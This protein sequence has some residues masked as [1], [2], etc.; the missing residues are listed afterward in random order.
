[1]TTVPAPAA[2]ATLSHQQVLRVLS[3]I[4]LGM[5]L[6]ALDQTII[7]TPLPSIAAEL[8]G[9]EHLSWVVAIYLLTSTVSTPIYGKLSDLY[10]RRRL[11]QCAIIIFICGSVLCALTQNMSQLI[12]ARAVQGLGGGG[13]ITLAHALLADHV[14]PRERGRYQGY[15][16]GTWATAS[17]GGPVLGGLFV[18]HLSWRWVFW[19]NLPIGALALLLCWRSLR[20]LP[21][22]YERRSIDYPGALLL[23]AGAASLLLVATW[24]GSQYPW[25]SAPILGIAAAGVLLFAL[26]LIQ[27]LR[28]IEPIL[29]PRLFRNDVFRVANSA[30]AVISMVV[31]GTTMLLPIFLQ[32][33]AGVSAA[34]SGLLMAPFTGTTVVGAFT[35][36]W[37]MRTTGRYK[38]M[39]LI[40]L[41]LATLALGLLATMTS[42]TSH[43]AIAG[44]LTVLGYGIGMSLP[45]MLVSVQNAAE[46]RD[47]GSATSAVNFFR[48]LGGSFGAATLWSVLIIALNHELA[49]RTGAQLA[50]NSYALLQGGPDAIARLA[51]DVRAAILPALSDAFHV[52]FAAAAGLTLVSLL[53]CTA[54]NERPLRT[55][56]GP[57]PAASPPLPAPEKAS[58][59]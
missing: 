26:F 9:V 34:Q 15:L 28:A 25:T 52:V 22:R 56:A 49:G 47:M 30:S 4:L 12:A 39:P 13:L 36:G 20:H 18:D 57:A 27:E 54:L 40:G 14:S 29:P 38:R 16:S 41:S 32:I 33:V 35:T 31:F 44:Y 8:S 42:T 46:P 5:F 21:Q 53:I 23:A 11:L 7:V 1:V 19:I 55:N 3:G 58:A 37:T 6:A 45:V 17:V 50:E 43:L 10:G 51:P 24:G 48:S 2:S 59:D